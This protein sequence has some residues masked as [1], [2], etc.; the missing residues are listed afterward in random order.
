MPLKQTLLNLHFYQVASN[1]TEAAHDDH[2]LFFDIEHGIVVCN[3][4][5][6]A[7]MLFLGRFIA[8]IEVIFLSL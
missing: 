6:C 7:S 4:N 2:L 5:S 1:E 3:I 8:Y